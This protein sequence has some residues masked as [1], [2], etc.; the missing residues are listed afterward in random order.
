MNVVVVSWGMKIWSA[1]LPNLLENEKWQALLLTLEHW[2]NEYWNCTGKEEKLKIPQHM[3]E[4]PKEG[5][6][7]EEWRV[8]MDEV[9]E[10]RSLRMKV[11]PPLMNS[12]GKRRMQTD[13]YIHVCIHGG[14]AHSCRSHR[15]VSIHFSLSL[16]PSCVHDGSVEKTPRRF[17]TNFQQCWTLGC[18]T[19]GAERNGCAEEEGSHPSYEKCSSF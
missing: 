4:N 18:L 12:W 13:V 11:Y 15:Q 8:G 17:K 7:G 1:R 16:R 5:M 19:G 9:T 3:W 6:Q 10:I 2:G 14:E